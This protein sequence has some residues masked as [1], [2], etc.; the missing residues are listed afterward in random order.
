MPNS[1]APKKVTIS[2]DGQEIAAVE[3]RDLFAKYGWPAKDEIL[4]ALKAFKEQ[5]DG[6]NATATAEEAAPVSKL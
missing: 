5:R 3:Q 1:G 4:P 2:V 6:A